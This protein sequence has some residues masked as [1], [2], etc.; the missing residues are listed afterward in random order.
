MTTLIAFESG[1]ALFLQILLVVSV[2]VLLQSWIGQARDGCRLWTICFV[3]I[4]GL[5]AAA[6]LLPH[7][8]LIAFPQW[9]S[10]ETTL[11]I[12]AVQT[13]LVPAL[14][15]VWLGG[16]CLSLAYRAR[17]CISLLRF[18]R[19]HCQTLRDDE[20]ARMPSI[21]ADD[22]CP[23][24]EL[25]WK[26]SDVIQG[27]FCWQLHRPVIVLPRYVVEGDET[28]LRHIML[29]EWEHL[30]TKHP[31]Q[32][33]LQGTCS[34][35]FWFHPAVRV[36]ANGAELTREYVCDEVAAAQGGKFA[37]YLRTLVKIAERCE[38]MSCA[39]IPAGTLA[40]GNRKS[41]L[42]RRSE[43]VVQLAQ[44][45]QAT[46]PRRGMIASAILI[47]VVMLA[48]LLWLPVNALASSRTVLSPWP[49]W[50]AGVLHDFGISV[51]DFEPF[52]ERTSLHELLEADDE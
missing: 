23:F 48:S 26:V 51:R 38:T 39:D 8:R 5:S 16:V 29:H 31:M 24:R 42:I 34:T 11:K 44:Q 49:T 25:Q 1:L 47:G 41:S 17:R 40:F 50:T 13:W 36:A 15:I 35:L 4:L 27:P 21:A 2:T 9:I 37:A 3:A 14:L 46:N 43:R 6:I 18:L 32:H 20:L 7:L 30:R 28:T 19:D 10:T 33:F 45:T 12:I 52:D 22:D